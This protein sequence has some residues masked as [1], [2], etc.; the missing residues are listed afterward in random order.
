M[1]AQ[2][3]TDTVYYKEYDKVFKYF[4]KQDN[5]RLVLFFLLTLHLG[6]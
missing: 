4:N 5:V 2:T 6:I 3:E 1:M